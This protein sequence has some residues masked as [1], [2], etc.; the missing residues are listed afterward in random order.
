MLNGASPGTAGTPRR[1]APRCRPAA[2]RGAAR[3]RRSAVASAGRNLRLK[4]EQ[5]VELEVALQ[6]EQRA[7]L[8]LLQGRE[9]GLGREQR[10]KRREVERD[11]VDSRA[12]RAQSIVSQI[13][14][15][16]KP[17]GVVRS[18]GIDESD[19][20]RPARGDREVQEAGDAPVGV[21]A[22]DEHARRRRRARRA[23][24]APSRS[25]ARAAPPRQRARDRL[26]ARR[27][28]RRSSSLGRSDARRVAGV[29]EPVDRLA[30]LADRA[31]FEREATRCRPPPRRRGRARA[32]R[33]ARYSA[34]QRSEAPRIAIRQSRSCA[35][36]TNTPKQLV[37]G[38]RRA[39]RVARDDRDAA[40]DAVGE[41]R[42]A[43]AARRSTTCRRGARTA[44]ACRCPTCATS[45]AASSRSCAS[46]RT[47]WRHGAS[48][49][50]DHPQRR[51]DPE[52]E[53]RER[54]PLA[55]VRR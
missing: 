32:G 14:H 39:D 1:Q 52:Q 27:A 49:A 44:R 28:A 19:S 48:H 38:L 54:E 30:H 47:R 31:A 33:A 43:P 34:S 6:R 3:R 15:S 40:D 22:D 46:C 26:R 23:G 45:A 17:F 8:H 50:G 4:S 18:R 42:R 7:P 13:S 5:V 2:G 35:W 16:L 24:R 11:A 10:R 21:E 12:S 41:E 55:E 51:R 53:E 36:A 9:L 37:E 29:L 25:R 20:A